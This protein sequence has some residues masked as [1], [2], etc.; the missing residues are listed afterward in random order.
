V[1]LAAASLALATL[2]CEAVV[3]LA[4][5]APPIDRIRPR[6]PDSPFRISAN[7]ILG[8]E[9]K[10]SFTG[11]DGTRVNSQGLRDVERPLLKP[12]GTRRIAI[13]GD[14]VVMGL[15]LA[16]HEDTIPAQLEELLRPEGIEVLNLGVRGYNTRAEVELLRTKGLG[17]QP[18]LAIVIFLR[19]DHRDFN[20]F[21]GLPLDRERAPLVQ[22]LFVRSHLFRFASLRLDLFWL[23]AELDPEYDLRRNTA[24]FGPDN[25]DAGLALLADLAREHRFGVLIAIW[26]GFGRHQIFDPRG[27]FEDESRRVTKVERVAAQ[28]G[29]DSV[30]LSE[31][32]RE[33]YRTVVEGHRG[34]DPV[35]S[36]EDY[37]TFD[38]M[39]PQPRGARATAEILARILRERPDL[40]GSPAAETGSER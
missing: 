1:L 15:Y 27:L 37:Y 39:H 11:P 4:G 31:H 35:P 16:R 38:G 32:F 20:A 26:P 14:S 24:A 13:L 34:S 8:Y 29:L 23:R 22:T 40:L 19:N 28:H 33:H 6:D 21:R 2:A 3:R 7:P 12:P 18:D 30:R 5:L 10:P 17:Y 9:L 36:P 25:V